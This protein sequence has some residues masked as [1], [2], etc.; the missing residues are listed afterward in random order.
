MSLISMVTMGP[1]GLF[2]YESAA[3]MSKTSLSLLA[4]MVGALAFLNCSWRSG[5]WTL[6]VCVRSASAP[7]ALASKPGVYLEKDKLRPLH[8]T[9]VS[10]LVAIAPS[11]FSKKI[12]K[13]PL[14][15]KVP[16]M[17]DTERWSFRHSCRVLNVA[18]PPNVRPTTVRRAFL[19]ALP[20]ILSTN[21]SVNSA[22][23]SK[24][25]F[26]GDGPWVSTP[27]GE[28]DPGP[29]PECAIR[30][31]LGGAAM[32]AI[33]FLLVSV[34]PLNVFALAAEASSLVTCLA[35]TALK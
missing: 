30:F 34:F 12:R 24:L 32:G 23:S 6:I 31:G 2:T 8:S 33:G 15:S 5:N 27:E 11:S 13:Y 28:V 14:V 20:C 3:S 16:E 25:R 19:A 35:A 29:L 7:Y 22:S 17:K 21:S 10:F 1:A 9:E 18:L 26:I 4:I